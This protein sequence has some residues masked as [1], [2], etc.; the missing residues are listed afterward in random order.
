MSLFGYFTSLPASWLFSGPNVSVFAKYYAK[1][2]KVIFYII[3]A[4]S[5]MRDYSIENNL[6]QVVKGNCPHI[7]LKSTKFLVF[8]ACISPVSTSDL[9]LFMLQS[10]L[11]LQWF[12]EI[13][14]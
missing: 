9:M 2:A 7:S 4:S 6:I 11:L 1:Y 8:K 10:T 12:P 13:V 14:N 5:Y 3:Y